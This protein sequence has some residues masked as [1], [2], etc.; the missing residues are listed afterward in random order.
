MPSGENPPPRGLPR[1]LSGGPMKFGPF[2]LEARLAV[3]GTAEVYVARPVD[4]RSEPRK[5]VVKRLLPHFVTDPEGQKMFE[6]EAALHAAVRHQNVVEVFGSGIV[7]DEPWLAM[8]WV[9]GCDLFRLLRRMNG[10]GRKLGRGVA[11]YIARA[12]LGALESVHTAR[13][14]NGQPMVI[15]HWDVTPS[16]VYLAADGLVKLGDFGIA[17]SANR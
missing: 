14:A 13:D 1:P 11:V 17:R 4:E 12:L 3:G 8:E 10:S 6:R 9:E 7:G 5:M 2:W 15:I 16:N